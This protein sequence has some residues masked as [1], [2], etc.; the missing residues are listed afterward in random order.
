MLRSLLLIAA[1]PGLLR[2]VHL[3]GGP[4]IGD[5]PFFTGA[6]DTTRVATDSNNCAGNVGPSQQVCDTRCQT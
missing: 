1:S 5:L 6:M 2:S 4:D 3:A